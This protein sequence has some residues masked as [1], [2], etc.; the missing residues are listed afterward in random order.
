M[1]ELSDLVYNIKNTSAGEKEG[2]IYA[3]DATVCPPSTH[4][5]VD[6]VSLKFNANVGIDVKSKCLEVVYTESGVA[7]FDTLEGHSDDIKFLEAIL[8]KDY[9]P[10]RKKW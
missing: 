6:R 5:Y 7:R 4:C 10:G 9:A 8:R 2:D 1:Q 3:I